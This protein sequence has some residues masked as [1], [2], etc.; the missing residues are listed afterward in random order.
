MK[1]LLLSLLLALLATG[2]SAV[3]FTLKNNCP[4]PIWPGTLSGKGTPQLPS[5]G[6]ELP[7]GQTYQLP[8]PPQWSGRLWA[9]TLCAT[10]RT[11]KFVCA[12]ADCASGQVACNGAGAIP[13]AT[14]V[15]LTLGSSTGKDFFDISLVDG[16]NIQV[17]VVP[18]GQGCSSTSCPVNVNSRC[19]PELAL[20]GS[21][22]AVLACKSACLAF[23]QPQYCC[24]GAYASPETCHPTNYSMIFKNACPQAYSYAFDDKSSTFTCNSG[25]DYNIIF[26]P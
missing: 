12:T 9:R 26:C 4:Y 3:T 6:F 7:P 24:S 23:N 19:P 1:T 2:S 16:Y 13:P 20:L 22:G 8:V 17:S 15:E 21:D 10:D 11:G 18:T 14:L 5:T 25:G